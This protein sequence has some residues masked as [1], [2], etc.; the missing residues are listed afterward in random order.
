[1]SVSSAPQAAPSADIRTRDDARLA[2]ARRVCHVTLQPL[3]NDARVKRSLGAMREAGIDCPVVGPGHGVGQRVLDARA[4]LTTAL[5][6]RTVGTFGV[7]GARRAFFMLPAHREALDAVIAARPDAIHAHDWDGC[8]VAA[9]A[10]AALEIP[11][12]YDAHE[13]AAE[14]HIERPAWRMTVAP[15]IRRLEGPAARAAARVVSVSPML[16]EILRERL[17][18]DRPVLTVRNI[19]QAVPVEMR[20]RSPQQPLLLHY[21]GV[22][23]RGRGIEIALDTVLN[24]EA[25]V[26]LRLLGPWRQAA[27]EREVAD[28]LAGAPH[29]SRVR[30]EPAI[31]HGE[32][33][34]KASEADLGLCLLPDESIHNRIALPNKLFEYLYAGIVP[35]VSGSDEMAAIVERHRCG[36]VLDARRPGEELAALLPTLTRKRVDAMRLR[37]LDAARGFSWEN[38]ARTLLG[39]YG[40]A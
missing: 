38:E 35:I 25:P 1:M 12:V 27:M 7:R 22:L 37:C 23:A 40:R 2:R 34:A 19:P 32:L 18:L 33:I 24:S 11:F 26:Q 31:A 5:L 14:M 13:F 39:I 6:Y 17:R 10:A 21:H 30:I 3:D 9:S 20:M 36:F 28:R 4:K 15:L 8:I 16:G 29:A